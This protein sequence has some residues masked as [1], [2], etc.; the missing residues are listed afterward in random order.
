[1]A[2][3]SCWVNVKCVFTFVLA[4]V[5]WK[6][7]KKFK[8]YNFVLLEQFD[9]YSFHYFDNIHKIWNKFLK[10][11]QPSKKSEVLEKLVDQNPEIRNEKSRHNRFQTKLHRIR[12]LFEQILSDIF[13]LPP[14][15]NLNHRRWETTFST[16][17]FDFFL[18]IFQL[19]LPL[20]HFGSVSTRDHPVLQKVHSRQSEKVMSNVG[21]KIFLSSLLKIK[22]Q[23]MLQ[24]HYLIIVFMN[25]G[26]HIC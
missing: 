3:F 17:M 9:H 26:L 25:D 2:K 22:I 11:F 19:F 10:N 20:L 24:L 23:F 5:V 1:M 14:T 21:E 8:S 4:F 7:C 12:I 15:H 13:I 18:E 6:L 16:K